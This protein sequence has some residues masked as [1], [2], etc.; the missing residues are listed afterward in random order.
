[1]TLKSATCIPLCRQKP[2]KKVNENEDFFP[3]NVVSIL[4]KQN[5]LFLQFLQKIS[6]SLYY[7]EDKFLTISQVVKVHN[8]CVKLAK[9]IALAILIV[10]V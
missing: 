2:P 5:K 9:V 6:S 8:L 3:Q 7:K 1:M 4:K 10:P